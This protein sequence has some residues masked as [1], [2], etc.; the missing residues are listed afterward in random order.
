MLRACEW[1]KSS[2]ALLV[3]LGALGGS[4]QAALFGDD[5]ARRAILDLRQRLE[6]AQIANQALV[7][8]AA[9]K[10]NQLIDERVTSLRSA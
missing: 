3:A 10:Q 1:K 9:R 4:A 8:Q 5:E 2:L 7:E 6:Q